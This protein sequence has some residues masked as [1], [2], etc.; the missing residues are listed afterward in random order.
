MGPNNTPNNNAYQYGNYPSSNQTSGNFLDQIR[1]SKRLNGLE[2]LVIVLFVVFLIISF[3]LGFIAAAQA[4]EDA[5][6]LTHINQVNSALNEYYNNSS[7]VPSQRSYPVAIC[8]ADANEVDFELT[9]RLALTGQIKE[10]DTQAY[11]DLNNYPRDIGGYYSKT[12]ASRKIAYR[13]PSRLSSS[14]SSNSSANTNI[15]SDG[16]ESCNFS[17]ASSPKCYLYASSNN[18]DTFTL[19]YYS[20][21]SNRFVLFT[22]FRDQEITRTVS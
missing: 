16:W 13:C 6:R 9:L 14:T 5:Q 18:G 19:G 10:K 8:S 2:I 22:K 12:L 1:Y 17:K 15:Y 4:N 21:V 7:A 20:Q 3:V 11:I